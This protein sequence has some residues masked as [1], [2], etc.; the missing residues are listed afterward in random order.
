MASVMKST[1]NTVKAPAR[2]KAVK[3]ALPPVFAKKPSPKPA[4]KLMPARPGRA[5]MP[6]QGKLKPMPAQ[7]SPK[8][9]ARKPM[10][11]RRSGF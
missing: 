3:P 11:S 1:P 9:P 8:A 10:I 4:T 5:D 6:L 2:K 7:R